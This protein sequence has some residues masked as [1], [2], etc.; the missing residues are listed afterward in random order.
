MCD[1]TGKSAPSAPRVGEWRQHGGLAALP[2]Y[3]QALHP[4]LQRQ[5]R[6][7]KPNQDS[8][9]DLAKTKPWFPLWAQ[10]TAALEA[11]P[12]AALRR[13]KGGQPSPSPRGPVGL[14]TWRAGGGLVLGGARLAVSLA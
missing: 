4:A 14:H 12:G 2:A 1:C 11:E 6:T 3:D 9:D 13:A 7:G 5:T 8:E 10:R